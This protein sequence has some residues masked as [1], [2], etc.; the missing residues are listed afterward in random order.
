VIYI[1]CTNCRTALSIQGDTTELVSLFGEGSEHYPDMFPCPVCA[2]K[3]FC[4]ELVDAVALKTMQVY[5]LSAQEAFAAINGLGLPEEQECVPSAVQR[6]LAD[7]HV[8]KT[9]AKLIAGTNRSVISYLELE[10]GTKIYLGTSPQGVTVYRIAPKRSYT[11][12][13]LGV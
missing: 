7:S 11:Q 9:D 10:N 8:T 13:V 12:E 3:A 1:V 6:A 2:N 5:H 4:V